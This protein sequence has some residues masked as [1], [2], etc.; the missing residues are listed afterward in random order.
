MTQERVR[1]LFNYKDGRLYWKVRKACRVRVGNE[2]GTVDGRGYRH[3]GVDG[4]RYK[5]HRLVYLY[6]HGEL[7][8]FLDHIDGDPSNNSIENLRPATSSQNNANCRVSKNNKCGFKGVSSNGKG[9]QAR[10]EKNGEVYNLG[11]FA[12]PE[13]AHEVY[14]AKALELFGEFANG[15]S[16]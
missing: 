13:E 10:V 15:G 4:E 3:V 8:R 7:P 12:T 1:E 14:C 6:H 9:F 2:A 11:T 16:E 5:T